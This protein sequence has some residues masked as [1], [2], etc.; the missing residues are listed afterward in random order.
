MSSTYRGRIAPTPTGYLHLGH[1]RTFWIAMERAREAR[2]Q[3]I[4]RDENLDPQRCKPEFSQGAIADLRWFGCDW[5]EG[6]DVGGPTGPYRQS[7][8]HALFLQAWARL[9]DAGYIYPCDKSRKDV[10]RAAQAPHPE[11][12]ASE[13]IYPESWRPPLGTG[14]AADSPGDT[15]WRFRVPDERC[16]EFDDGRL[17]P[18]AFTCL[19]DFGDF[20]VWRKDGV[21]AYELAVVVDDAAMQIS[22][23]VRGEDLL[24]STARQLLLYQ[25]L[26]LKAPE[27]YHTPLLC[28]TTGQRLAKRNRSLT[29]RE[30]KA[31]GHQPAN[32]RTSDDWWSGLEDSI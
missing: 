9:K 32:L 10:A 20:L 4:F 23:V 16:I 18:C 2:G 17:G 15:N 5:D 13:P 6:P 11:E 19:R 14:Q 28:D 29:L 21:P 8:R 3:L 12:E 31:A 30:L 24:I 22:E 26:G 25:A 27:F 1:A 7:E